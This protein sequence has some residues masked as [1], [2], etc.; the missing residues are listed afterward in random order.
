MRLCPC[1]AVLVT[2]RS[3]MSAGAA[4]FA[5]AGFGQHAQAMGFAPQQLMM[6]Q[7]NDGSRIICVLCQSIPVLYHAIAM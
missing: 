7:V 2:S 6:Q 5:G 3:L 4:E 1:A